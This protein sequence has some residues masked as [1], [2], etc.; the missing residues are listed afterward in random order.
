V[1]IRAERDDLA[2]V[3][4]RA[5]RGVA[6]RS[7]LPIL[8]GILCE[9]SGGKLHVTGT[10][11]EV[12]VRTHLEVEVMEEGRTVIP[13]R[14]AAEAVRKLPPG[15]VLIS[16]ADGEVE[17]TGSGPRFRLRELTVDDYPSLPDRDGTG[18]VDVDGELLAK[19][20]AQV[21]VASSNDDNRPILTGVYFE[22][23]EKGL[24]LVATDSYRLAVRD[25]EGVEAPTT[26]LV[27][28]RGLREMDRSIGAPKVTVSV[29]DREASFNSDRGNLTVRLIEGSFP[30]YRQLLPD[31]MPN[32][33]KV[34][35]AAFLDAL[36]RAGLV[37][38]EHIPVRLAMR[39]GGVE[40]T[41][42]RQD[43][44]GETEMVEAEYTGEEVT[45]AFNPRYLS[46]GVAAVDDDE[47]VIRTV[48]AFKPG[49]IHGAGSDS[50]RYLL[51]PVRL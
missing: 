20:L 24:R 11:L 4:A 18:G 44:G 38:E 35:K 34:G 15:A 40:L 19:A 42:T 45:I 50:F 16:V 5:A 49:L 39:E 2:D 3:L 33:L 1:R 23:E 14:L 46:D 12:T 6:A 37:A 7:P 10:D 51:M 36:D 21:G 41:V 29:G 9:V 22:S 27:P 13:A 17:I 30:N 47:I 25:L 31:S 48:E 8:Q 26:G 28:F 32:S 43:V